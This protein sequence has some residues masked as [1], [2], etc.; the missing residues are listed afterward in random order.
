MSEGETV[1]DSVRRKWGAVT[2]HCE[3]NS[4][5]VNDLKTCFRVTT[6]HC[7]FA[8]TCNPHSA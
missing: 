6:E 3:G 5:L 7:C 8:E 4:I 2:I 1:L